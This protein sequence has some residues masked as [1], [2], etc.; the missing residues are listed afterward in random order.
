MDLM[1]SIR[2]SNEIASELEG[3][4]HSKDSY[5]RRVQ[6]L[7]DKKTKELNVLFFDYINKLGT[8]LQEEG[9]SEEVQQKMRHDENQKYRKIRAQLFGQIN[10]ASIEVLQQEIATRKNLLNI[11]AKVRKIQAIWRGRKVR[12][13]YQASLK[14][15]KQRTQVAKEVFETERAYVSVLETLIRV[16]VKP[17]ED[18]VQKNKAILNAQE[19]NVVFSNLKLIE[20][21]NKELLGGLAKKMENWTPTTTIGDVFLKL[22]PFLKLY[23]QYVNNYIVSSNTIN[24][25]METNPNFKAFLATASQD[26]ES[27]KLGQLGNL[28]IQPVQRVPRYELL[29]KEMVK[30]TGEDH[31]DF[32][33]LFQALFRIQDINKQINDSKRN[34]ENLEKIIEIQKK[35]ETNNLV[36][37]HRKLIKEGGLYKQKTSF[38]GV[39]SDLF[40][41][42]LG[43]EADNVYLYLFND[44]IVLARLKSLPTMSH[45]S[46]F[47]FKTMVPLEKVTVK[48]LE[49][50]GRS[51][52]FI[53]EIAGGTDDDMNYPLTSA[54]VEATKEW[55]NAINTASDK[56]RASK[57]SLRSDTPLYD[58]RSSV[59]SPLT[60][61]SALPPSVNTPVYNGPPV[62]PLS[63]KSKLVKAHEILEE[64]LKI[65]EEM[66]KTPEFLQLKGNPLFA[67]MPE[68]QLKVFKDRIALLKPMIQQIEK[69]N[70]DI[71]QLMQQEKRSDAVATLMKEGDKKIEGIRVWAVSMFPRL[72]P[73]ESINANM[74]C[75][76][77]KDWYIRLFGAW[78]NLQDLLV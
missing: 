34:S 72:S 77:L 23:T 15:N 67:S 54:T 51:N 24:H 32:K 70:D 49:K 60:S 8:I 13:K 43:Y 5:L 64:I 68:N 75:G 29:L 52:S 61:L 3:W 41:S 50:S 38:G 66:N 78:D 20:N 22:S 57:Q 58:W 26:P 19:I 17:L 39:M 55:I 36:A 69:G 44:V 71:D 73:E 76:S 74:M 6:P 37:P 45:G 4:Q 63:R 65:Q 46:E 42:K 18:A 10:N 47:R 16:Y 53:L 9:F 35:L 11:E 30:N 25:L 62:Q 21:V 40:R 59:S 2:L 33:D 7:L 28:L 14:A 12:R 1:Q 27:K 31:P 56:L 48:S